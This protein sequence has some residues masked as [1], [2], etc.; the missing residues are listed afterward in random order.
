MTQVIATV[1][2]YDIMS[3]LIARPWFR[4][5]SVLAGTGN[6]TANIV[7]NVQDASRGGQRSV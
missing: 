3:K 5:P 7:S 2:Y 1:D 6:H 4:V